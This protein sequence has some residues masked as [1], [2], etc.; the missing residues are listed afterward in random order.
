M[1]TTEPLL[2]EQFLPYR[3]SVLSNRISD[4]IA[5]HYR[6]GFGITV[7]QWRVIAVLGE[8]SEITASA[9]AARTAMDKVSVSRAVQGLVVKGLL[10]RRASQHDGRVAYLQLSTK[11]NK[12]YARIA[13][14]ALAY[15]ASLLE[16]LS[17]RER[18]SLNR[19]LCKLNTR[20]DTLS[21]PA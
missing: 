6:N 4:S 3:L 19:I 14:A 21:T 13:P 10:R 8:T 11:G 2:L 9:V 5:A 12:I 18:A 15:E 7:A 17:D 16:T 20:V 1:K